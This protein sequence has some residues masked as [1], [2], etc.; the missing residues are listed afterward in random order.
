MSL[1]IAVIGDSMLDHYIYGDV[2]RISPEAPVPVIK[3]EHE[4]FSPGGAAH[5]A[6][7]IQALNQPTILLTPVGLDDYG[8]KLLFLLGTMNVTCAA[9]EVADWKTPVKTRVMANG[10]QMLRYDSETP[11]S[12]TQGSDSFYASSLFK[13][14]LMVP[15]LSAIVVSDYN[16]GAISD[17]VVNC[18]KQIKQQHPNL[19]LFV[20]CKPEAMASWKFADVITPNFSEACKFLGNTEGITAKDD[21]ACERMARAVAEALPGVKLVVI[22]RAQ[23]GCSWYGKFKSGSLPAFNTCK[24]DVIGAGDTFIAALS[25]AFAAGKTTEDAIVFA[26]A[27]SAIAVGKGGTTVVHRMEL[28]EYLTNSFT[29]SLSIRKIKSHTSAIDWARQLKATGEKIVFTNGCFDLLHAGH[30]YLLEQAKASGSKLIVAVNDDESI[31]ILKGS[32]RPI[33]KLADRLRMLAALEAVDCVL[34]FSHYDL[35]Q[36]VENIK[37]DLL[38]KGSEYTDKQIP[39]AAVVEKYG[40]KVMLVDMQNG[41]ATTRIIEEIRKADGQ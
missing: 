29:D 13:L 19:P 41:M 2:T 28:D 12:N 7:S 36:L 18:L 16:K 40:G 17:K 3:V 30:V 9:T 32:A 11:V 24:A 4:L 34:Q 23:H 33:V 5:V 8:K 15:D 27:A 14:Q 31:K 35:E 20:D 21:T 6:A 10:V 39:G 38:V 26:N 22:T 1:A 37:P 25:V